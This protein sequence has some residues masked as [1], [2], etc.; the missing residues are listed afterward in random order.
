MPKAAFHADRYHLTMGNFA[1]TSCS[2]REPDSKLAETVTTFY[3]A[4]RKLPFAPCVGHERLV[5]YL[6]TTID[7]PRIRFLKNDRAGLN[8]IAGHL[9]TTQMRGMMRT[10]KPGTIM[11][12]SEPFADISGPFATTQLAEVK[13]E[14][15]FDIPLTVASRALEMRMAAGPDRW[16]SDFSLRRNGEIDRSVDVAKYAIIAG[17]NDTSNMEAAFLLDQFPIGTMAHYLVQSYRGVREIDPVTYKPK[18]FQQ[19]CFE[20]WLD[21]HPNGTTLLLD[22]ISV[23]LGIRHAVTAAQSSS[24]RRKAFRACRIDTEPLGVWSEYTQA[25]LDANGMPD[26]KIITTGDHDKNSIAEVIR[27]HPRA[28]GFGVGTKLLAEVPH[29]AGVVF[30]ECLIN[31]VPTLKC[32]SRA[33]AT[34]P[35]ALQVWRYQDKN[36]YYLFDMIASDHY[37]YA[38]MGA[39]V[40]SREFG[41]HSWQ[42]LLEE[43]LIDGAPRYQVP[44]LQAQK[45]FVASEIARFRDPYRYP[46]LIH[47]DLQKL[48]D[49]V[50]T[51]MRADD[52]EYPNF[53]FPCCPQTATAAKE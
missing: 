27:K 2:G 46:V 48:I 26:V 32:S 45:E 34:L 38:N 16:L 44:S 12:P 29:V 17:F 33:K 30:K 43:F 6:T 41:V 8:L 19:T 39:D 10:V 18:H 47:P 7:A 5:E 40:L 22:T 9:E 37:S 36:G 51:D 25:I 35:G 11:F 24:A 4:F 53:I 13:F 28:Y 23:S 52:N 21:T 49:E 42:P 15:A 20:K 50:S 14:H 3:C 1:L 31:G